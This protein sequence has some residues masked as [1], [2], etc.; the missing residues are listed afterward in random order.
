MWW[1][2]R[3]RRCTGFSLLELIV[4]LAILTTVAAVAIPRY[5]GALETYRV[6]ASATRV[7]ADLTRA[8]MRARSG[9]APVTV[10]FSLS[11]HTYAISGI[12]A[13]MATVDLTQPP[14]ASELVSVDFG[15]QVKITFD[16]F[17]NPASDGTIVVGSGTATK[18]VLL[19]GT[20]GSAEVQ[21]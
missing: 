21:P 4:V 13:E 14:Y 12:S 16:G 19:D 11:D 8:R 20:L 9:S 7:A 5:S 15:G 10:T 2:A 6:D 3:P 1:N 18:T 17:G